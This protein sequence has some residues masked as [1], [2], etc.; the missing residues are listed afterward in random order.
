[1]RA[2]CQSQDSRLIFLLLQSILLTMNSATGGTQVDI[3]LLDQINP[4]G[5]ARSNL[6]ASLAGSHF[7]I[8]LYIDI[9]SMFRPSC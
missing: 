6:V 4:D 1:M 2:D 3:R 9:V 5:S 8:H 7:Y